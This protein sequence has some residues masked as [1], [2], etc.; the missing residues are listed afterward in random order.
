MIVV[1]TLC[2]MNQTVTSVYLMIACC[3][4]GLSWKQQPV[5]EKNDGDMP[6]L[7]K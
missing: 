7:I 6:V 2:I 5:Y 4:H 1:M 3:C